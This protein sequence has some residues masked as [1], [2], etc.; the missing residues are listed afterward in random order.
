V[1]VAWGAVGLAAGALMRSLDREA[2]LGLLPAFALGSAVALAAAGAASDA[3]ANNEPLAD[4][5]SAQLASPQLAV[6]LGAL[7]AAALAGMA[8]AGAPSRR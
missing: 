5:L 2:P 1:L 8:V 4:H 7:L 6:A 3:L